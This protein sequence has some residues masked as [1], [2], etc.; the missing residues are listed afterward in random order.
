MG[1]DNEQKNIKSNYEE[2]LLEL[3]E[4]ELKYDNLEFTIKELRKR[5]KQLQ[6]KLIPYL[7]KYGTVETPVCRLEY[8]RNFVKRTFQRDKTLEYIRETLGD[9]VADMVD[10]NCT[11][12]N[13]S[14]GLWIY[15]KKYQKGDC[16]NPELILC[17]ILDI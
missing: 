8:R 10:A 11:T 2:I 12:V 5:K 1:N 4:L 3:I 17:E 6:E 16:K 9:E 14:E 7:R 13:T 15:R